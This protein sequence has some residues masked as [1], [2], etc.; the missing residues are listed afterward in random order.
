MLDDPELDIV[1]VA[2]PHPFHKAHTLLCLERGKAVLCE[3]PMA[4]NEGEVRAMADLARGQGV[5][6]MEAMWTRFL[7]VMGHVRQWLTE[8]RIGEVRILSADFGFRSAWNPEGRLLNPALAGGALLDVGVYTVALASMIYGQSP[9]RIQAMAHIGETAV[10]EQTGMLLGY[11]RGELALLTCAIRTTTPQEAR[12][13]G[14]EGA[15]H[16]PGFWH[17]TSATLSVRE[18]EP[19]CVSEPA[20]YHYEAA[21]VMARLRAGQG[22]S[23]LMPLDESIAIARTLDRIRAIV[24]LTYPMERG[25]RKGGRA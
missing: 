17:A 18:Q 20:G 9:A 13:L 15:I 22:E 2:T 12:I 7:P 6:L 1:Y 25:E 23:A 4:V 21:E 3:K 19:L 14:T 24:G 10:D 16:I 5:F 8:K 11:E